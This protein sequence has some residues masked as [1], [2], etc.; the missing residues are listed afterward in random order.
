LTKNDL[1]D[2]QDAIKVLK[3]GKGCICNIYHINTFCDYIGC[4]EYSLNEHYNAYK[5]SCILALIN[6]VYKNGEA[7]NL[8]AALNFLDEY[9]EINSL[10]RRRKA[11]EKDHMPN[12]DLSIATL[13]YH[14]DK[15]I[16]Q[17]VNETIKLK[18]NGKLVEILPPKINSSKHKAPNNHITSLNTISENNTQEPQILEKSFDAQNV[19]T[20]QTQNPVKATDAA[21]KVAHQ[22][23]DA[24]N[25]LLNT[26]KMSIVNLAIGFEPPELISRET[27]LQS[28]SDFCKNE[29]GYLMINGKAFSG[30][31]A[32]LSWFFTNPPSDIVTIGFFV[33][34]DIDSFSDKD[35]FEKSL[36]AQLEMYIGQTCITDQSGNTYT[37]PIYELLR[38]AAIVAKSND[39][40]LVLIIDSLDEDQSQK[41]GKPPIIE[42]L[43]KVEI[44]NL[45][46]ILSSRPHPDIQKH[47][48]WGY[49]HPIQKSAILNLEQLAFIKNLKKQAFN[50]LKRL[51]DD[52]PLG[53]QIISLI[54][55][56][57][58]ALSA[59]D[60]SKLTG[61]I[62]AEFTSIFSDT[63]ERIFL[64]IKSELLYF[65]D[66]PSECGYVLGHTIFYE[67]A[68]KEFVGVNK[69]HYINMLNK[70]CDTI[71]E[72]K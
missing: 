9:K 39:K 5:A 48:S 6:H 15:I 25:E 65:S 72:E 62:P 21:K 34:K 64:E 7:D 28:L 71:K 37:K 56:S 46:V 35:S 59:S 24:I 26:R 31:T 53:I 61:E 55:V 12:S 49:N 54:A 27:E 2:L 23:T 43:P 20:E 36:T 68:L 1:K 60:F 10:N 40:R 19:T 8:L 33:R 70:W 47:L 67:Q 41:R 51:K 14:E 58:G 17:L 42:L 63:S 44:P 69:Q 50:E 66:A 52:V 57:R 18:E 30:K 16:K 22:S 32:L 4:G 38:E 3:K 11:Y 29:S 13:A 45:I